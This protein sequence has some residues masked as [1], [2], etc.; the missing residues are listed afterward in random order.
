MRD[1]LVTLSRQHPDGTVEAVALTA[2]P[3]VVRATVEAFER[4]LRGQPWRR[5]LALARDDDADEEETR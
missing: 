2:D 4:T 3:E 1:L 5:V